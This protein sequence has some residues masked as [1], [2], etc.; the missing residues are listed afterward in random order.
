VYG[1]SRLIARWQVMRRLKQSDLVAA[2]RAG[3]DDVSADLAT[4]LA[5]HMVVGRLRGLLTTFRL[6]GNSAVVDVILPPSGLLLTIQSRIATREPLR[7]EPGVLRTDDA[8]FDDAFVVEGAPADVI[9]CLLDAETRTRLLA[10]R[11]L[12]IAV[13]EARLSLRGLGILEIDDVVPMLEL[14]SSLAV[15]IPRAIEDADE[16]L[17]RISG[18]PYRPIVDTSE[19]RS[20]QARRAAELDALAAAHRRRARTN[21]RELA[22]SVAMV[23]L[24]AVLLYASGD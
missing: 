3:L 19:L 13:R 22:L 18:S 17:T 14:A 15:A 21:R 23:V 8:A 12:V 1:L 5:T 2:A 24:L 10:C 6:D 11:P 7:G 4:D 9:R 20:A 16:H